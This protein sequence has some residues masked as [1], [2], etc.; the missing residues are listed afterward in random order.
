MMSRK[1]DGPAAIKPPQVAWLRAIVQV[2]KHQRVLCGQPGCKHS[3]YAA[4]HVIEEEGK[5]FALGSTCFEKRF[6][7]GMPLGLPTYGGGGGRLL[8][9]EER[10]LLVD[11]TAALLAL[12]EHERVRDIER[13]TPLTQ[14][15]FEPEPLH[16]PRAA[17]SPAPSSN[18]TPWPWIAVGRSMAYFRL[19]DGSNWVRVFHRDGRNIL[20]PWPVFD[21]WEECLPARLGQP[22]LELGGI[23]LAN[24][25]DAVEYL[26]QQGRPA[27]VC[28][29]WQEL[30]A[31]ARK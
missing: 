21:G 12:F 7:A 13:L 20:V 11:N 24:V 30:R 1:T 31:A 26:Q 27:T 2:G 18:V 5:V 28:G 22:D 8:T 29:T 9:A 14:R 3:V 16:T 19:R 17:S 25:V 23:P 6:G 15:T 10:K 4:I